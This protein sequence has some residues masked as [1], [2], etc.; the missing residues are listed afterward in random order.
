MILK[1]QIAMSPPVA[2]APDSGEDGDGSLAALHRYIHALDASFR[3]KQWANERLGWL[4]TPQSILFAAYALSYS[5]MPEGVIA[6]QISAFQFI[7]PLLGVIICLVVFSALWAAATMHIEWAKVLTEE[8]QKF[9][10]GDSKDNPLAFGTSKTIP[11]KVARWAAM[12]LPII[13][14]A[15]WL[16]LFSVELKEKCLSIYTKL[17]AFAC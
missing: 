15:S 8:S 1:Y 4:F 5:R 14:L 10:S 11:A 12:A 6:S 16:V 7:I 2:R 17:I 3:E 9:W 13:F